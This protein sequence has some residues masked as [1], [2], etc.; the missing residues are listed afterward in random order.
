MNNIQLKD[1]Y[2]DFLIY[3]M[4][5]FNDPNSNLDDLDF[6]LLKNFFVLDSKDNNNKITTNSNKNESINEKTNEE[7]ERELKDAINIIKKRLN[8]LNISFNDFIAQI[9]FK[10]EINSVNYECFNIE[11]FY[12][13]LK[14]NNI[15]LSELK[16]T[17]ICKK[18]HIN[19]NL[20]IIDKGKI[21][22]D[23]EESII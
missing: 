18:Y 8:F 13:L 1:K 11:N 6:D 20:Q 16:L 23:I 10:V 19:E 21:E 9:T 17:C 3:Y 5:K 14:T 7:H 2:L 4:K 12:L 15:I 22:K